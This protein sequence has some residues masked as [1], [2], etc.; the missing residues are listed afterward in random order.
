VINEARNEI[1]ELKAQNDGLRR[2][3]AMKDTGKLDS[4]FGKIES[5]S[6]RSKIDG[7]QPGSVSDD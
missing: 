5:V 6:K 3:A 2:K 1:S 4:D 7:L